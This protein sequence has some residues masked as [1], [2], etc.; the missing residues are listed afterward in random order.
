MDR[1]IK[2]YEFGNTPSLA[3]EEGGV[4]HGFDYEAAEVSG[5]AY[6]SKRARPV[7]GCTLC[8]WR[9]GDDPGCAPWWEVGARRL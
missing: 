1:K 2:T 5:D 8:A 4:L 6:R 7:Q 3:F 9:R